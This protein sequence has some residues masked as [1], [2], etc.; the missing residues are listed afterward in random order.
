ME[1]NFKDFAK[2]L[3][4]RFTCIF[5]CGFNFSI[6]RS[7]GRLMHPSWAHDTI[8]AILFKSVNSIKTKT[9]SLVIFVCCHAATF[10][11]EAVPCVFV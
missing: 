9:A 3:Y 8:L 1:Y 7:F 4:M 5:D 11:Q 10:N 2:P 6:T